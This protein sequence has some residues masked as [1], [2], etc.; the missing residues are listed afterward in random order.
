MGW[1]RLL[2]RKVSTFTHLSSEER[3]LLLQALVLLPLVALSLR[4]SGLRLTQYLLSYLPKTSQASLS[5]ST[6]S[7]AWTTARMVRVA[8]RY[9]RL[10]ANCLKRSL[11]LWALLHR[12]GIPSQLQI[13]VQQTAGK[14]SAHAWVESQGMVL[15]EEPGVHLQFTP[16]QHSFEAQR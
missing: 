1:F 13:G 7:Q 10:W 11:V 3:S 8:V 6:V 2:S 12:Q 5:G 9:N 14:F 4:F 16:F 15:N